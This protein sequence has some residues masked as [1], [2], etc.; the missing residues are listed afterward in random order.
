MD[1]NQRL[2]YFKDENKKLKEKI[3]TQNLE[4]E[5]AIQQLIVIR[6]N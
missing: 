2:K 5:E 4:I 1:L 3:K 6:L